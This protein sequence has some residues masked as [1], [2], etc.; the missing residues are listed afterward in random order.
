MGPVAQRV[1]FGGKPA[2]RK[3]AHR[4]VDGIEPPHPPKIEQQRIEGREGGVD[5]PQ[6]Q[7]GIFDA[8][9]EL[10]EGDAG[11]LGTKEGQRAAWVDEGEQPDSE[12]DHPHPAKPVGEGAQQQDRAGQGLDVAVDGGACGGKAAHRLKKRLRGAYVGCHPK[13]RPHHDAKQQP[14]EVDRED[15]LFDA[16]PHPVAGQSEA[17]GAACAHEGG[18][19][20]GEPLYILAIVESHSEGHPQKGRQKQPRAAQKFCDVL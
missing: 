4:V 10:F 8:G 16:H 6:P 14:H 3:G 17:H 15:R 9:G 2:G 11:G 20:D 18:V 1:V 7:G 5:P 19:E 12:H 13:P